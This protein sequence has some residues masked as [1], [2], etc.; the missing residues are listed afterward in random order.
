MK[1]ETYE[2]VIYCN[3]CDSTMEVEIKKGVLVPTQAHKTVCE[4]CGCKTM[5]SHDEYYE[6]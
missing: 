6:D 4:C 3:N 1:E 5:L 2:A